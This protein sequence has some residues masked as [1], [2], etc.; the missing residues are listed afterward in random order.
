[1]GKIRDLTGCRF[2]RQVAIKFVGKNKYSNMLWL[3]KCDCG[4][5]HVVPSGKLVSGK[6][7]SCGCLAKEAAKERATIHGLLSGG[8]KPRTFIIWNGMK[9]RCF[10][11]KS[12]SYKSYGARGITVCEDWLTFE[13]FHNW[14]INHGYSD[15]C[16]IDR[17]DSNGN[18]EPSN[19][20]WIPIHDNRVKQRKVRY[21]SVDG[22]TKSISDWIRFLGISKTKT[23]K[24]LKTGGESAFIDYI[25]EVLQ[26]QK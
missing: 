4:N 21:I 19:C 26:C 17:I 5:E 14:A 23:Y 25:K 6:S 18:Y 15:D 24:I 16:E 7:R 10:N 11:P 1:M 2:G 13:N 12:T 9:A 22:Q 3:C 20:Q 8:K